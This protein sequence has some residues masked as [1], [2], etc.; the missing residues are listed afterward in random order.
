MS[1]KKKI[2]TINVTAY[3]ILL[4][5]SLY[6]WF[7]RHSRN[8]GE[9]QTGALLGAC[10][11]VVVF[12]LVVVAILYTGALFRRSDQEALRTQAAKFLR[13]YVDALLYTPIVKLKRRK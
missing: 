4:A 10:L 3:V 11:F 1:T 8:Y 7:T 5:V 9:Y 12:P 6:L 13:S 2:A